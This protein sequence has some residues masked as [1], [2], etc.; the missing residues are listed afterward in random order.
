MIYRGIKI[1]FFFLIFSI[2]TFSLFAQVDTS[3]S[4][5]DTSGFSTFFTYSEEE[6]SKYLEYKPILKFGFGSFT[7]L[8]DV[9]DEYY[10]NP[11]IGRKPVMIGISRKLNTF[12]S[13]DFNVIKGVLS[14]LERTSQRN[15]N[16]KTDV[17][18]GGVQ[19]RY[20]FEHLL[21]KKDVVLALEEY[22]VL[23]PFFS[24][25]FETMSFNSKADMYDSQGRM[26]HYWSD[27]ILR[28]QPEKPENIYTATIL[29]R[30]YVYETDLRELNLDSLGKYNLN[31]YG[32]PI[33]GGV[34]FHIHERLILEIGATYHFMMSDLIDNVS[35]IGTG[36]RK[37]D[38]KNDNFLNFYVA[39]KFDIFSAKKVID[40]TQDA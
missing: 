6:M 10:G 35:S 5:T 26:Y 40:I 7:F 19:L 28:E 24:I 12:L 23:I 16:F 2:R 8:G 1:L 21:K 32:I 17:F 33:S 15:L 27:G 34:D 9:R 4:G 37:G 14:G 25:G 36:E 18:I 3:F 11:L 22:R 30:D 31:S 39:A 29:H 38:D 20:N 13:L